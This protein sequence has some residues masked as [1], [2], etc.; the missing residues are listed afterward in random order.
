VAEDG[1]IG[2]AYALRGTPGADYAQRTE[3]NVRDSD[4][5][6]IFSVEP[7]L[8]GGT[9]ATREFALRLAKPCLHICARVD[10]NRAAGRL[11]RFLE[12]HRIHVLNVAGPRASSEP[13]VAGFVRAVL[14]EA[15]ADMGT[16]S[17]AVPL[18]EWSH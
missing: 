3:W 9:Q 7:N 16:A 4:G 2:A 12:T 5:T 14:T 18:S 10:G 6:V 11:R 8:S 13:G 17:D 15:F 1:A